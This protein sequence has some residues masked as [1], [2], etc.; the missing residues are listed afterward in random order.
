MYNYVANTALILQGA[1]G[2]PELSDKWNF[3]ST[4]CISIPPSHQ[5]NLTDP[6]YGKGSVSRFP[7]TPLG[8]DCNK[9]TKTHDGWKWEGP[10]RWCTQSWWAAQ[11]SDQ[12]QEEEQHGQ[13][14]SVFRD[15]PGAECDQPLLLKK[16]TPQGG[17]ALFSSSQNCHSLC[18]TDV[19]QAKSSALPFFFMQDLPRGTK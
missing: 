5:G 8:M 18:V 15:N 6:Y 17:A 12:E 13:Y 11:G 3:V 2:Y 1:F 10:P 19:P 9:M 16:T 14:S 4:N 7:K